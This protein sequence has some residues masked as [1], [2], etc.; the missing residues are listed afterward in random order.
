MKQ[1]VKGFLLG[2]VTTVVFSSS[3]LALASGVHFKDSG[4]W[5]NA[6]Q[7]ANDAGLMTGVGGDYFGGDQPLTRGQL[8][9]V[10]KNLSDSGAIATHTA[11]EQP[12]PSPASSSGVTLAN[13]KKIQRGMT[14][15]QVQNIFGSDGK[16]SSQSDSEYG[17]YALY[18]WEGNAD[19]SFVMISFTDGKATDISQSGL[20]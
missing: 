12:Q 17:S 5:T 6:A 9:Q 2:V 10:L 1:T 15:A 11:V 7:W 20:K 18:E 19:Y 3:G 14:L 4:W 16:I 8:A 13:Y